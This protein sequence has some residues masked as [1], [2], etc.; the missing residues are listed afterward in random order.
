M[1]F[2]SAKHRG[3]LFATLLCA[4]PSAMAVLPDAR[5]PIALEAD[6]SEFDRES[7]KLMFQNVHIRQGTLSIVADTARADDLD[8]ADSSWDFRGHVRIDGEASQ[9]LSETAVLR[10]RDHRLVRASVNGRP[11]TFARQKTEEFR[12]LNGSAETIDYDLASGV[13]TLKGNATL[14]DGKN[15]I[16]GAALRYELGSQKLVASSEQGGDTRVRITVTP[17]TL[18]LEE[19]DGETGDDSA[20]PPPDSG[21]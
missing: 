3:L 10:F 8:F 1:D 4:V 11:A 18:G 19:K 20:G 2:S 5:E 12:A 6:S 17:Q 14:L 15:E 16:T 7:G 9:I 13:L 21:R